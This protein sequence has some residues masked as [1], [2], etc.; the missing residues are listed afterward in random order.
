MAAW[1][2]DLPLVWTRDDTRT[3]E[4]LIVASYP[5]NFELVML[6]QNAGLD[7]SMINQMSPVRQLVREMLGKARLADRLRG[8][9]DSILSDPN[10]AGIHVR[11]RALNDGDYAS[12]RRETLQDKPTVSILAR[13][14]PTI[15]AWGP[16]DAAPV[17]L[18][19][20]NFER[21][22]N[23]AAGFLDPAKFRRSIA[24]AEVRTA[25][26]EIGG[27]A[28]G[29]GFLI[30]PEMLMTN[31]HVVEGGVDGG[32]ARFDQTADND[33]RTVKFATEWKVAGSPHD[34]EANELLPDGPAEGTWD[35]AI[36]RLAEPVG[37]QAI[38]YDPSKPEADKR[39]FYSLDWG[40]YEFDA[41]EP[42]LILGHPRGGPIQLSHASPGGA[43][44]TSLRSRVRYD[45][46]TDG[47]SSGS[48]VFNRDFRV[49]ALHHLG[50]K[51]AGPGL[52]NQGVPIARI[53]NALRTQLA[54]KQELA[55]LGLT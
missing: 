50:S 24:E 55:M 42:L 4:D 48:P 53:G 36:I 16:D 5:T 34:T 54:G 18:P 2:E 44:F 51:G 40:P 27:K 20:T 3:A 30:G 25:R 43:R 45:T 15:V 21:T 14:P 26:I 23:V 19:P 49:V 32:L 47:G 38:G 52:F 13:L 1:F 33:G 37:D 31:W 11:L 6:G 28:K 39:S 22:T 12:V 10:K 17:P 46:N 8:L 9:L 7:L 35:F 29:T 41:T